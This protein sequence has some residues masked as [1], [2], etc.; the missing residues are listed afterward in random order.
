MKIDFHKNNFSYLP[1]DF[2]SCL[3][4]SSV[5]QCIFYFLEFHRNFCQQQFTY[6]F[7][8]EKYFCWLQFADMCNENG[9]WICYI[10][11][12]HAF[13]SLSVYRTGCGIFLIANCMRRAKFNIQNCRKHYR[14]HKHNKRLTWSTKMCF[15]SAHALDSSV[16]AIH[17]IV[18]KYRFDLCPFKRIY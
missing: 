18:H 11:R 1:V 16:A 5:F 9:S 10:N 14:K 6:V 17:R 13:S 4:S 8:G 7:N 12:V 3:V 2:F 15:L